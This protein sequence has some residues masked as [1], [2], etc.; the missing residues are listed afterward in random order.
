MAAL[1]CIDMHTTSTLLAPPSTTS[2]R[3]QPLL[4]PARSYAYHAPA[5]QPLTPALACC[6]QV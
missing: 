6:A 1:R 3:S 4:S 5:T 2:T